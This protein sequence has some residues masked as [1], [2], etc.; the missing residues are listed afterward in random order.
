MAT[1]VRKL[2]DRNKQRA[3]LITDL[4]D[5][6]VFKDRKTIEYKEETYVLKR[7]PEDSKPYRSRGTDWQDVNGDIS[8]TV[9]KKEKEVKTGKEKRICTKC[10]SNFTTETIDYGCN[11]CSNT[12]TRY[13]KAVPVTRTEYE[14]HIPALVHE[15]YNI[16]NNN[17][18]YGGDGYF[19]IYEIGGGNIEYYFKGFIHREE[20]EKNQLGQDRRQY[21]KQKLQNSK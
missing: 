7:L 15:A 16:Q 17:S 8:F 14:A 4:P 9:P 11:N 21:Q 1:K 5:K 10:G 6:R 18:P 2:V 13:S 19:H 12:K 3:V 20:E